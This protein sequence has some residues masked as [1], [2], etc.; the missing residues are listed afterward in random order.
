MGYLEN[1]TIIKEKWIQNLILPINRNANIKR[2]QKLV[3]D[4]LQDPNNI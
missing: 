1:E 3:T 4:H 2:I